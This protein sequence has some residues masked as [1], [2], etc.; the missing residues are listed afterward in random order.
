MEARH[1]FEEDLQAR[2]PFPG[3]VAT[4]EEI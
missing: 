1:D 2:D 4:E 3:C